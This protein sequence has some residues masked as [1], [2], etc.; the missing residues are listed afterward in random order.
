MQKEV[1]LL[2]FI[3]TAKSVAPYLEVND[4][5]TLAWRVDAVFSALADMR[6]NARS[7]LELGKGPIVSGSS[8]QN[9]SARSSVESEANG[10]G[11]KNLRS[12]RLRSSR[13]IKVRMRNLCNFSRQYEHY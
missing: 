9:R 6:N 8:I 10:V 3:V 13:V 1:R 4:I 2:N 12:F 5:E 7:I 11:G